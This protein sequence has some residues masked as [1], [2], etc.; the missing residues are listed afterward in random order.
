MKTITDLEREG[1]RKTV[2]GFLK[3]YPVWFIEREEAGEEKT[4]RRV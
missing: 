1:N 3:G 4:V 2:K